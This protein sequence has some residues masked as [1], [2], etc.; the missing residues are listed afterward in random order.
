MNHNAFQ[1]QIKASLQKAVFSTDQKKACKKGLL[2]MLFTSNKLLFSLTIK[3]FFYST[4][5]KEDA[6]K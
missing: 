3:I 5:T 1:Y 6:Y 2:I 4:P